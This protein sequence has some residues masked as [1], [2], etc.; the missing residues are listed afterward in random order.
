M[1]NYFFKL[2]A[3]NHWANDAVINFLR[4]NA[5]HDEKILRIAG[6]IL[7]A[8][9][10]WF[11]RVTKEQQDVPVWQ[12][13]PLQDILI[14]LSQSDQQWI[15]YLKTLEESDFQIN[16][17]YENLAGEP[18]ISTIE[19]IMAHV[20]NHATYHRGQIIYLIRDLG[21]APPTTDYIKFARI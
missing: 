16:L 7:L 21:I 11:K 20:I 9:E 8:Q 19:D 2:F 18:Q 14:R 4:D 13:V 6:H 5:I 15:K 12:V 3:F 10:N 1:K 17:D